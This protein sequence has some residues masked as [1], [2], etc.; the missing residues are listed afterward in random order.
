MINSYIFLTVKCSGQYK[1]LIT[2]K[3]SV[4]IIILRY[5]LIFVGSK[6]LEMVSLQEI[7]G[8]WP[9]S[10]EVTKLLELE[11]RILKSLEVTKVIKPHT[12]T[13]LFVSHGSKSGVV[14]WVYP[15][16]KVFVRSVRREF[17]K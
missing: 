10:K 14:Q 5:L 15:K 7:D 9:L 13:D 17:L 3:T 1:V 8:H 12:L 11:E 6:W 16:G 2:C 4:C